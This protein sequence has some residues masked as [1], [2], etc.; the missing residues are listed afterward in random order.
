M[1]TYKTTQLIFFSTKTY[2][3][4]T[5]K[6]CLNNKKPLKLTDSKFNFMLQ[7]CVPDKKYSSKHSI[8]KSK[9]TV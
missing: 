3:V 4:G 2:V 6:K 7:N 9:K 1:P 8:T 5:Q